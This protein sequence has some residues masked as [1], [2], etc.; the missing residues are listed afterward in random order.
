M[1]STRPRD[2]A[3]H[4]RARRNILY[5]TQEPRG[6]ILDGQHS[7]AVTGVGTVPVGSNHA[8]DAAVVK[9]T[10]AEVLDHL[11]DGIDLVLIRAKGTRRESVA[12]GHAEVTAEVDELGGKVSEA[13]R[14]RDGDRA[15]EDETTRGDSGLVLGL[16]D[17]LGSR[18]AAHNTRGRMNFC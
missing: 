12:R 1:G 11:E 17:F 14:A 15:L 5:R 9:D 18:A 3:N 10:A 4:T 8:S 7:L 13:E 2:P 16:D 6:R